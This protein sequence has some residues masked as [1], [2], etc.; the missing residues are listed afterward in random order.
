MITTE[1]IRVLIAD[2]HQMV[3]DGLRSMLATE[4]NYEVVAEANNGQVAYE[5]I[6]A[7]PKAIQFL[8]TDISMPLLS[9]PQLCRMVKSEFPHIQVLILSM[10]NNA[11]AV[12]EA[13]LAE[14]DGYVLKNTGKKELLEAMHRIADGGTYFSQDIIPLIYGQYHQQKLQDEQL[15]KLSQRERE[16]LGLIVKEMTSEEIADKLFISKKTVDNHRQH[17]LEKTGC[18]STVGLVKFAIKMGLE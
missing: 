17:L 10:Y 13:V 3:V 15:S 7:D 11:P 9:G 14:A 1:P 5:L 16:V 6:A 8:L 18:K 4:P 2:D 12:K